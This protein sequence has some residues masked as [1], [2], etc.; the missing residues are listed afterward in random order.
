MSDVNELIQ[1]L[2]DVTILKEANIIIGICDILINNKNIFTIKCNNY[3]IFISINTTKFYGSLI[4]RYEYIKLD[5][6]KRVA[7]INGLDYSRIEAFIRFDILK[8]VDDSIYNILMSR[9]NKIKNMM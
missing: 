7:A 5:I 8:E 2:E 1:D 9:V 6:L 4:I 3:G